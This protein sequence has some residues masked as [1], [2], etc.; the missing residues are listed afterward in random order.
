[1]AEQ[2]FGRLQFNLNLHKSNYFVNINKI[3]DLMTK[4]SE[5]VSINKWAQDFIKEVES[6]IQEHIY[7]KF[8]L[9]Q[10]TLDWSPR[11]R[12][13]RGGYY[14]AGPGISIAMYHMIPVVPF[15]DDDLIEIYRVYEYKSFDADK[16][17]GGIYSNLKYQKLQLVI[18]HEM[19]H[20]LQYYSYR[21]NNFRCTPHGITFKNFYRRLRNQFLNPYLPDQDKL[22]TLYYKGVHQLKA[23]S[24]AKV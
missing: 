23:M 19:A 21:L 16:E 3:G 9:E 18:L 5:K 11:R 8:K 4:L 17:I 7:K 2:L 12:S 20:A 15:D 13:S 22:K 10:I 1:M 24:Y 14:T 6:H